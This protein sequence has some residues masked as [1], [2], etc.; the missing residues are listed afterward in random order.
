MT[1]PI[2]PVRGATRL[3]RALGPRGLLE[4]ARMS[5]LSVRRL[6]KEQFRGEGAALLLT[7]QRDAQRRRPVR[8]HRAASSVGTSRASGSSTGSPCPKAA[9]GQLT[10]ALVRRLI[11][12]GGEIRCTSPV[13]RVVVRGRRAVAV[14]LADGDTID[15]PRGVL[16]DVGAPALYRELVGEEHL[17]ARRWCARLERFQ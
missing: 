1:S 12:R 10:A 17:P 7:G 16:A 3:A 8:R 11:A 14:Q 9:P 15:A 5:L 4:F 6:A 2:P 13:T